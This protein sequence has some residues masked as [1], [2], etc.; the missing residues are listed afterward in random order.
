MN[1][2]R[3]EFLRLYAH[4]EAPPSNDDCALPGQAADG[5]VRAMRLLVLGKAAWPAVEALWSGVQ[6][7]DGQPAPAISVEATGGYALW[8]SLVTP[9]AAE[10]ARRFLDD[11]SAR[12]LADL[13]PD[14][15]IPLVGD[16]LPALPLE[17]D[18]RWSAFIDPGLGSL[19]ADDSGLDF[20]PGPER[21]LPLLA[22]LISMRF[23]P[24]SKAPASPTSPAERSSLGSGYSAPAA[25]LFAVMNDPAASTRDRIEAAKA[26]LAH[27]KGQS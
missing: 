26:L 23:A 1:A 24:L 19:F 10:H 6:S 27:G 4:P 13:L 18:G 11:L 8:F 25:F 2:L 21:Q 16:D 14:Q 9:V 22:C 5:S 17:H 20:A 7:D 3:T 12:Y 15:V